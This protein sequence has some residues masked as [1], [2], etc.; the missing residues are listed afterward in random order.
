MCY[1]IG[2]AWVSVNVSCLVFCQ[3]TRFNEGSNSLATRPVVFLPQSRVV[4]A[5]SVTLTSS[6][7]SIFINFIQSCGGEKFWV[8][9]C[10]SMIDS[11]PPSWSVS[12]LLVGVSPSCLPSSESCGNNVAG[13]RTVHLLIVTLVGLSRAPS[14]FVS[15]AV[16]RCLVQVWFK[17]SVTAWG[18]WMTNGWSRTRSATLSTATDLKH[19]GAP[20]ITL[21]NLRE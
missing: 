4:T 17:I 18:T 1:N 14:Y 3:C 5:P 19:E 12:S 21:S 16:D 7:I 9:V 6:L 10:S 2:I 20:R 15:L 8:W 13:F 11:F